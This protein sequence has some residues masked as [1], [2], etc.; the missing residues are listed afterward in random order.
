MPLWISPATSP[1]GA[2]FMP[3]I[4]VCKKLSEV[5][6]DAAFETVFA[7]PGAAAGRAW[8]KSIDAALSDG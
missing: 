7:D 2:A 5:S 4:I 6:A 3:F 8:V 1:E